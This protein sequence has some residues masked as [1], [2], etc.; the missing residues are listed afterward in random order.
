M[1]APPQNWLIPHSF[2]GPGEIQG[3]FH[4]SCVCVKV[5]F[6]RA[7]MRILPKKG[8]MR[9]HTVY[10][11]ALSATLIIELLLGGVLFPRA[12]TPAT[13]YVD[14]TGNDATP[15]TQAKPFRTI[16]Q[17]LSMLQANDT[18]YLRGGTYTENISSNKQTIPAG[19]S[20]SN[21]VT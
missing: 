8:P 7:Y 18:L 2:P 4:G 11:V 1:R 15:R 5:V 19:T 14:T 13:Y 3:D 10:Q 6:I 12:A 16:R 20:W 21:A 9:M 17:G